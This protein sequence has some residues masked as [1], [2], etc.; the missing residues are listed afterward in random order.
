[1]RGK[2]CELRSREGRGG[3]QH[4][5]EF[6]H[7]AKVP[8]KFLNDKSGY[9][10]AER[11][12]TTINSQALGRIVAAT[13]RDLLLFCRHQRPNAPFVHC[14]F[15]TLAWRP[16]AYIVPDGS[17]PGSTSGS[18]PGRSEMPASVAG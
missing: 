3:E 10:S 12:G 15:R 2:T 11:I 18:E 13:K 4:E 1:V 17:P 7:E 16:Q 5:A 14:A 6:C 9:L 8:G